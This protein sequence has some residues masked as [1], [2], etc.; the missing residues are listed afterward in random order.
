MS[1]GIRGACSYHDGESSNPPG[2]PP[3]Y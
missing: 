3:I 1:G 2:P